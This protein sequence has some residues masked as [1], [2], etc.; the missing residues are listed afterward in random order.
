MPGASR[1]ELAWLFGFVRPHRSSVIGLLLSLL[2]CALVLVQPYLTKLMIDDGLLA[3]DFERLLE[4]AIALLVVGFASTA[5]FGLTRYWHGL[6]G[7]G[8]VR[9]EGECLRSPADAQPPVPV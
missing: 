7:Q 3:G 4:V 9:H 2:A 6:V 1:S 5:L 8:P